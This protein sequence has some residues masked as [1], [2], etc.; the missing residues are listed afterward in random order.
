MLFHL[1]I[2]FRAGGHRFY[3][4]PKGAVTQKRT[5]HPVLDG[6]SPGVG[7]GS[8]VFQ[9]LEPGTVVSIGTF[10]CELRYDR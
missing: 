3:Q 4:V 9:P 10:L 8:F 5:K 2:L 1:K 7:L 6:C